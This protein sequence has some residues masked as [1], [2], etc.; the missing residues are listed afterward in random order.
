MVD[1]RRI[2]RRRV[3]RA[4]AHVRQQVATQIVALEQR[5]G[6]A[7]QEDGAVVEIVARS[8][9]VDQT[10]CPRVLDREA[11]IAKGTA[12]PGEKR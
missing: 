3:G 10:T 6:I 1:C 5:E 7:E 4:S 2:L 12:K 11:G 9:V 8:R